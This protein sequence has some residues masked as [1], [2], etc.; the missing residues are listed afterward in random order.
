MLLVLTTEVPDQRMPVSASRLA[1]VANVHQPGMIH[2][3]VSLQFVHSH[4]LLVAMQTGKHMIMYM[5]LVLVLTQLIGILETLET[6]L[7]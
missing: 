2:L 6:N 5:L 1:D 3:H 7:A 4:K